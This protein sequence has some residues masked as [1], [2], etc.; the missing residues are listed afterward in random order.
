VN[1]S[2]FAPLNVYSHRQIDRHFE[3]VVKQFYMADLFFKH[4]S[5]T[6]LNHHFKAILDELVVLLPAIYTSKVVK[7]ILESV[8]EIYHFHR[9]F[10]NSRRR[11]SLGDNMRRFISAIR[12]PFDLR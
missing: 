1:V 3:D 11:D 10:K 6:P 4:N 2:S 9:W 7:C 8:E 12:F 5:L